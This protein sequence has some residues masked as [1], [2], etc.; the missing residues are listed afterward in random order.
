[1]IFVTYGELEILPQVLSPSDKSI[2]QVDYIFISNSLQ[3]FA[4]DPRILISLSTDHSPVHLSLFKEHK[5]TKINGFWKFNS[6]LIK[7]HM[8][9][10]EIKH[11]VSSF[12]SNVSNMNTR[13]KWELLK[14]EIRKF[15]IDYTKRKAKERRKQQTYLES[16]LKKLENNLESS[17]NLRKYESL[18]NNLELNYDHIAEGVRL[19]MKCDWYEQGEKSTKS[20]LNL[21]KQ[22]CNENRI[23]KH[24]VNEKEINNETEILNQIKLF[25]ETLFQKPSQK[26]SADDINHFL[27]TQDIPKLSTDQIILCDIE[28]TEKGLYDSMKNM[29]NDK[30]PGNEG[31]T[32]EFYVTF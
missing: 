21:E 24:I 2:L 8:Y 23:R 7:D 25:Y 13:L 6:S 5:H 11:L 1:M 31:L 30:F 20:F 27:N 28:L 4:N 32:K 18:K 16:D 10:S 12:L 29:E 14:Y 15:T 26:Y 22:R 3:E 17:E 9:V 19:R